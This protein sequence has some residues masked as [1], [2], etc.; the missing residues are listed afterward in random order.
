MTDHSTV[1]AIRS[2]LDIVQLISEV[3]PLQKRGQNFFGICP[4]HHEKSPSFSVNSQKQLFHCFGCKAGGDIFRFYQLYYRVDFLQALEDLAKKAGIEVKQQPF[5][6]Q[7]WEESLQLLEEVC[8]FYEE[9][10]YSPK[11]KRFRDYLNQ[12]KI[13][14]KCWKDFR[15]GAHLGGAR[16][17]TEFLQKKSLSRDIAVQLG[18]LGRTKA[19]QFID[20]FRARLIFSISDENGKIRGF[21]ARALG[22]E[23]PKY[24]N[25]PASSLF[26]KKRLLYGMHL[27]I[28]ELRR[29]EYIVLVEGYLDVIALHEFGVRNT[30]GS[31]GTALTQDQVRK[32]KRW[33]GRV[34]SLY[35]ADF[36]GVQATER[37]LEHFIAEGIEAKVLVLPEAK[38][39]DAFLHSSKLSNEEKRKELKKIF[40]SAMP[41]LD[42]LVQ[43][44]VLS[45]KDSIQ[46]ARALRELNDFLEKV[47]DPIER[48]VLK[49][50]LAKR[51]SLPKELFQAQ[52]PAKPA[53]LA[54]KGQR[55]KSKVEWDRELLKFLVLFGKDQDFSLTE[56]LPYLS[57]STKWSKLLKALINQGLNSSQITSL[58]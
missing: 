58:S 45:Q 31:M 20:R 30:V 25:S 5:R 27:A 9:Q 7:K 19:G 36:A 4:F 41:A 42:Y 33:S 23:S 10:L 24:I 53:K 37:N 38:D 57:F 52:N 14:E 50:D 56:V 3:V 40:K 6:N 55:R 8:R 11:A 13:P 44:K 51:F 22:N 43:R 16:E 32:L 54:Q 47:P 29:K 18:I 34:I 49:Q 26:D 2:S 28:P 39:P 35:D 21:G 46:K 17:L 1:E 12:R 15:L 48:Q